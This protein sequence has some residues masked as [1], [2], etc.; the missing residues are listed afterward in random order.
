[1]RD[2]EVLKS[3]TQSIFSLCGP[4]LSARL[5]M[6][7]L[8]QSLSKRGAISSPEAALYTCL[9]STPCP[10]SSPTIRVPAGQAAWKIG[11]MER[12]ALNLEQLLKA[13]TYTSCKAS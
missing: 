7:H 13:G 5:H 11:R 12:V 3:R 8:L 10:E 1:M 4:K 6:L 2:C 9:L